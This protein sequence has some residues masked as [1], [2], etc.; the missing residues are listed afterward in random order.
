ML[1][2]NILYIAILVAFTLVIG[3]AGF[4]VIEQYPPFDAFYMSLITITTVGYG[5]VRPLSQMGR[6][7]NSFLLLFGVSVMFFSVGVITHTVVEMRFA[8]VLNRRRIRKMIDKMKDHYILCGF[9]RV[10]RG[11]AAEMKSSG[12]SFVVVDR[13]KDRVEMAMRAG[14]IAVLA[15]SVRDETL[16]EAGIKQ[17]KGLIAALSTD[18]D[19]VFLILSAKNL[20]PGLKVAAR[21]SEEGSEPKMR[22]AGA[23]SVFT[24]YSLTGYRLAQAILRPHVFEFLDI[25]SSSMG[26]R[27]GLEQVRISADSTTAG[28]SLRDL[29]F[30]R[31]LGVIVLAIRKE[32]GSMQFNPSAEAIVEGGDHLIVLGGDEDVR[33]L[34]LMLSGG[35]G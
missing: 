4:I 35:N 34:E 6:I 20:N 19:N 13:N 25:T 8:D 17:A 24:P 7:F 33:K 10:G 1:R 3:T 26:L 27:M 28:K 16:V 14:M 29:Q 2:K 32:D 12:V 23:D 5:E 30:R 21:V 11:A 9:G 22:L 31:D 18:A 15:D